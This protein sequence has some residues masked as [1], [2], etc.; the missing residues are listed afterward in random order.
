MARAR[1]TNARGTV[2]EPEQR[3][4][5]EIK[6][7]KHQQ[8]RFFEPD[9]SDEPDEQHTRVRRFEI[10]KSTA[11]G[12]VF[13]QDFQLSV[14]DV[15]AGVANTAHHADLS[16]LSGTSTPPAFVTSDMKWWKVKYMLPPSFK[17]F[18]ANPECKGKTMARQKSSSNSNSNSSEIVGLPSSPEHSDLR[19]RH[20]V[21]A[22]QATDHDDPYP[23]VQIKYPGWQGVSRTIIDLTLYS[24]TREMHHQSSSFHNEL[25]GDGGQQALRNYLTITRQGW[26]REYLMTPGATSAIR[27]TYM[28]RSP[29]TASKSRIL[30][31]PA[32]D[33][34]YPL[35]NGNLVLE[36]TR[37]PG[38]LLAV[39]KQRR[40]WDVLGSLAVFVDRLGVEYEG[41][42][43]LS[44]AA[45]VGSCL[46]VVV[47][48]RVGWQNMWGS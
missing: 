38:R 4:L 18:P 16:L 14:V 1:T 37:H 17:L 8:K 2:G 41:E 20:A 9:E 25:D 46:A 24:I 36:D 43:R 35:A 42:E 34:G 48:E 23:L 29:G 12:L 30:T 26:S 22:H 15:D 44:V 31:Q 13:P 21:D 27:G 39:Y 40:D 6:Q 11:L 19:H 28:W 45:V 47:Y 7:H 32:V 5:V 33:D 3:E 10:R